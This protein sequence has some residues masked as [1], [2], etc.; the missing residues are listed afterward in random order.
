M[1]AV[2]A[3]KIIANARAGGYI[4][5]HHSAADQCMI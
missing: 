2:G 5:P 1:I 3:E 4:I